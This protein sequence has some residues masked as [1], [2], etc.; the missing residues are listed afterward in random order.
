MLIS[1]AKPTQL[2]YFLYAVGDE[3]AVLVWLC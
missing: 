2:L 1:E 3:V